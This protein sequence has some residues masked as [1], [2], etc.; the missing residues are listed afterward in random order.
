MPEQSS[1]TAGAARFL[2]VAGPI[3]AAIVAMLDPEQQADTDGYSTTVRDLRALAGDATQAYGKLATD[4]GALGVDLVSVS[5]HKV[6]GPKGVGAM[7]VRRKSPRLIGN[8]TLMSSPLTRRGA[9][10]AASQI[11]FQT[12]SNTRIGRSLTGCTRP[13]SARSDMAVKLSMTLMTQLLREVVIDGRH[14]TRAVGPLL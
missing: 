10:T 12:D 9:A 13:R 6:Y 14:S 11:S 2:L 4:F 5:A 7:F 3:C 1:Q 8:H